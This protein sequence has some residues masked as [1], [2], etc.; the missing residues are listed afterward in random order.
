MR[1]YAD[2]LPV[3]LDL[4][5]CLSGLSDSSDTF[6]GMTVRQHAAYSLRKSLLKKFHNDKRN[7]KADDAALAKFI[8][9][10]E[11]CRSRF[12]E[13][14]DSTDAEVI[15]LGEAKS[16]IYNFFYRESEPILN[17]LEIARRVNVGNGSNIGSFG[18]DFLSK[19]GTSFLSTTDLFLHRCYLEAISKDPLWSSVESTRSRVRGTSIVKGS[20]LS[21]VPKTTEISRTICTEPLL[22]MMFQQGI[23]SILEG[24][25]AETL[26][27]RLADQPDK[28]RKLAQIGSVS[29]RFGT[30]DL[31]SASDTISLSLIQDLL[32][33]EIV[34]FF[35]RTRCPVTILPDGREVDL[36]MISS[37][38]NAFTFPLQ[39]LIFSALVYGCY[40][41]MGLSIDRPFGS[42]LGNFAVFGDDI[43][44]VSEAYGFVCKMLRRFGFEVNLDKSFN[45]GPFRESCGEDYF[46]SH[47]IRG[48][49]IKTLRN[50]SDRY[51]AINR[52]N[53]WSC[54]WG[55]PLRHTV[56]VLREG[57]R[58]LPVPFDESD[59]SGMKMPLEYVNRIR[60]DRS[61]GGVQYR[62]LYRKSRQV[63]VSDVSQRVP[64]LRGWFNNPDAVLLA[65]VAGTLRDGRVGIRSTAPTKPTLR[66]RYTSR[67]NYI[68]SAYREFCRC[69]D[70]WK[71]AIAENL[72]LI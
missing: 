27:I 13:M 32:P 62:F 34:T 4:D 1:D 25:L 66:R 2:V 16:F 52:L 63:D 22:N 53:R 12:P 70:G 10:N 33:R 64:K 47:N 67:W 60:L 9:C 38:G 68:P 61:T 28:N 7:R 65:A 11:R 21:F 69:G 40:R 20:R 56:G 72:S 6:P 59:D 5:L 15:A 71:A 55:I 41:S 43:I 31:S 17:W 49:Y 37:M 3:A 23:A 58:I 51:S 46:D 42:N 35:T 19:F 26:G 39:T 54:I 18:T 50:D 36:H 57:L 24:R 30:I 45:E 29:G 48:V 8:A 14:A 44:V